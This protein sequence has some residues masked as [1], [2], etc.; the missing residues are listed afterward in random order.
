VAAL[1]K[2]NPG[3]KLEY[4]V[5]TAGHSGYEKETMRKLTGIMDSLSWPTAKK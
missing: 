4:H 3:V 5:T 2:A 1:K